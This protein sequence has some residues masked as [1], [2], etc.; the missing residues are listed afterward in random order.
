MAK[1]WGYLQLTVAELFKDGIRSNA[2]SLPGWSHGCPL[3]SMCSSAAFSC[4][5]PGA[6]GELS[7]LWL[8]TCVF[9]RLLWR[10]SQGVGRASFPLSFS[11][12]EAITH[13]SAHGC[14][15]SP[16]SQCKSSSHLEIVDAALTSVVGR[17]LS[18]RASLGSEAQSF[19]RGAL[20]RLQYKG[21]YDRS[22]W[23]QWDSEMGARSRQFLRDNHEGQI[24]LCL[25]GI[26]CMRLSRGRTVV[27]Y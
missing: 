4:Y 22:R 14:Y 18:G 25:M 6:T 11:A 27:R 10:S 24:S 5:H 13:L 9:Y 23:G 3:S 15:S 8:K 17:G 19:P 26:S 21:Q 7:S 2:R 12:A 20:C 1:C 16:N